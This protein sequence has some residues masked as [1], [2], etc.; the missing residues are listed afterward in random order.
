MILKDF[1]P[2]TPTQIAVAAGSRKR[3]AAKQKEF[4][5]PMEICQKVNHPSKEKK[6]GIVWNKWK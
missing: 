5:S 4:A 2:L 3:R 6:K 1:K